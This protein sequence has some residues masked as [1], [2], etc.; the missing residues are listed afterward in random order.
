MCFRS[1]APFKNVLGQTTPAGTAGL[2]PV[3]NPFK[4]GSGPC[5]NYITL[6]KQ[7]NVVEEITYPAGDP[8]YR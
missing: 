1:T 4:V 5:I 2:L 8:Y 3:C 7:G 6:T